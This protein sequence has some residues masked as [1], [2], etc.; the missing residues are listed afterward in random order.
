ITPGEKT[1]FLNARD[2][3]KQRVTNELSA[4]IT[5]FQ[6]ADDLDGFAGRCEAALTEADAF[7]ALED[8]REYLF[9]KLDMNALCRLARYNAHKIRTSA[10]LCLFYETDD[11]ALLKRA[12]AH[13]EEALAAWKQLVEITEPYYDRLHLGPTGGHWKDNLALV[14]QDVRRLEKVEEIFLKYGRFTLGFD[15]GERV[16]HGPR[17]HDRQESDYD[18]VEPRFTRI[19]PEDGYEADRGF[20]WEAHGDLA[21]V[22][23][24]PLPLGTLRGTRI[25]GRDEAPQDV[26]AEYLSLDFI[27]GRTP[28]SFRADVPNGTYQL[29]FLIGDLSERP[30][31]HGGMSIRANG[32][33]LLSFEI[34]K[35]EVREDRATVEVGQGAIEVRLLPGEGGEWVLNALIIAERKPRIGHLPLYSAPKRA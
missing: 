28:A 4:K 24:E 9:T 19:G 35:G 10:C 29:V 8:N 16:R 6:A 13:A 30:A 22:T 1:L 34:P 25:A 11:Y 7:E 12:K 2:Y 32:G 26:P 27:S 31:D 17:G 5:P 3:A 23:R 20:G 33:Q 14:E 21:A 15:F 18:L